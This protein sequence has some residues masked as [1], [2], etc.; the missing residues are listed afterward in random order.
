MYDVLIRVSFGK[1]V[2]G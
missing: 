2:Q 1:Y